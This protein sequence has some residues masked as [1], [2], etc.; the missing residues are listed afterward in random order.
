LLQQLSN[1]GLPSARVEKASFPL[2]VMR[3]NTI[4]F[5]ETALLKDD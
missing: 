4:N 2:Y 1:A 3:I 5:A